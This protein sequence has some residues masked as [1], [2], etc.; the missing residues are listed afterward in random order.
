[1]DV[2]YILHPVNL[3]KEVG[4][5][6]AVLTVAALDKSVNQIDS[7]LKFEETCLLEVRLGGGDILLFGC[8]Q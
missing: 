8:V 5:G 2:G 6:L 1:M 4:R 3:D 7:N